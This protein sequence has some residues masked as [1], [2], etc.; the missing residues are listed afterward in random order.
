MWSF[1]CPRFRM[2]SRRSESFLTDL[3]ALSGSLS[4]SSHRLQSIALDDESYRVSNF[5]LPSCSTP[6][7]TN[8]TTTPVS[9]RINANKA[10]AAG[11]GKMKKKKKLKW[12]A[13]R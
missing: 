3:A 13:T 11:T 6:T 12:K 2:A 1:P 8:R 9:G 4:S 7:T 5:E 10:V